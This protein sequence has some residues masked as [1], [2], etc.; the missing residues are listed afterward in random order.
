ML[1]E[2]CQYQYE[3]LEDTDRE[4]FIDKKT[5]WLD[6]KE[7]V[8]SYARAAA[9]YGALS[10]VV[11][12]AITLLID[13]AGQNTLIGW[14]FPAEAIQKI[15]EIVTQYGVPYIVFFLS[16]AMSE[17]SNWWQSIVGQQQA[18]VVSWSAKSIFMKMVQVLSTQRFS[19]AFANM[20]KN[21]Y[22]KVNPQVNASFSAFS[23]HSLLISLRNA[24]IDL[25]PIPQAAVPV[26]EKVGL[27]K[28]SEIKQNKD[29]LWNF[30]ELLSVGTH[31]GLLTAF[32]TRLALRHNDLMTYAIPIFTFVVTLLHRGVALAD[33]IPGV[34]A[35]IV[36][37]VSFV[38]Y[39]I[40]IRTKLPE[41]VLE[42]QIDA[43]KKSLSSSSK[44]K[45]HRIT[46]T[47]LPRCIRCL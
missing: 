41:K 39:I 17:T 24:L 44:I 22:D 35:V 19:L 43:Y 9:V 33:D 1:R 15:T 8:M 7:T 26:K 36:E 38:N 29:D 4:W 37:T 18:K 25:S 42:S 30:V 28:A 40:P 2:A 21:L 5:F 6:G 23:A 46:L 32:A 16:H 12:Y 34:L 47:E 31:Y 10:M 14:F 20:M 3:V 13:S 45:Q 11:N 27:K